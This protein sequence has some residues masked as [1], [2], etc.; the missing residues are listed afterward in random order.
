VAAPVNISAYSDALVVL[1]TAGVVVPLVRRWGISPVLGYLGA[2]ALL[3]PLGLGSFIAHVPALYWVTVVDAK[4]V[5]GIAELGVVFLLFL[6]GLE[7]SFE[8]LKAMRRLVFGLGG[9]QVI[10]TGGVIAAALALLGQSGPIA[11]LLGTCLALSSTAIVLD[12]LSEQERMPTSTGR[13][14]FSI[15]LAQD[16]AVIPLL[17]FISVLGADRSSSLLATV[18]TALFQALAAVAVIVIVGRTLLRPLF[19]LVASAQSSEI[20]DGAWRVRGWLA[21]SGNRI[22]QSH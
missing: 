20:V 6:I 13:L 15:L 5:A 9:L 3:G 12:V 21:V 7:L 8:R 16:L 19:R 4:N 10:L 17:M 1:G 14:S 2:G 11:I 18:G 22:P